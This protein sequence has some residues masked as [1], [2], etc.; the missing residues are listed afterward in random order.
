M[1]RRIVFAVP[2]ALA[3]RTG[4]Y[5]YAQRVVDGL[6][7]MGCEVQVAELAGCFPQADEVARGAAEAALVAAPQGSV[8]VI[9]GLALPAFDRALVRATGR[10]PVLGFIH[11]PL[12]L[13]TGLS[14]G[15][16]AR[17]GAIEVAL[18]SRLDGLICAS[19]ATAREVLA[20]GISSRRIAV[21]EP[22]VDVPPLDVDAGKERGDGPVRLLC[23]ATVT[24]RKNHQ[25]LVKALARVRSAGW[26]LDCVG[27]LD[28]DPATV[29]SLRRSIDELGLADRI[30]LHGEQPDTWLAGVWQDAD[31][32]VLASDHEGY[33]MVYTEAL[34]QGVPIVATR[35]GATPDT[36]P[37]SA[38]RLVPPRDVAA[39]AGALDA[40]ISSGRQRQ[41]LRDGARRAR[42]RLVPW[43]AAVRRWANALDR[44]GD[45]API[46]SGAGSGSE[47]GSASGRWPGAG[48]PEP[49]GG[50]P[51]P[52]RGGPEPARVARP[53]GPGRMALGARLNAEH[54]R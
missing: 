39:L 28:R 18:W 52:V 10:L 6:R 43:P 3:Q 22:G 11:H 36:I 35:A 41:T 26:R 4:G 2:G 23:V 1:I 13:E 24:P 8:V 31:L 14:V 27:S 29:A 48:A 54:R 7:A 12:A 21:A 44:L 9:D 37:A 19:P 40:L 42:E 17:L 34:A 49:A 46:G 16:A 33:G 20:A 32:F 47:S 25:M 15:A 30:M 50:A 38:C 5:L 53:E 51:E 45:R